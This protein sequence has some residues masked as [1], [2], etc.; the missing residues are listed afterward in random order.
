MPAERLAPEMRRPAHLLVVTAAEAEMKL[1]RFLQRRLREARP[2]P[3]LHKWIRSGQVRINGGRGKAHAR[4]AGGDIVRLPPFAVPR[5]A[6]VNAPEDGRDLS[7]S[8]S[9]RSGYGPDASGSAP[10]FGPGL[11]IVAVSGDL[12]VLNKSAGLACHPGS[13]PARRGSGGTARDGV[14]T[15]LSAAFA[16]HAYIP[17]PAHRLDKR[18]S[19]LLL[20]GLSHARARRLH[21]LFREGGIVR[22]YLAWVRGRVPW[23]GMRILEDRMEKTSVAGRERACAQPA[24]NHEYP[25]PGGSPHVA[26]NTTGELR[27]LR[28]TPGSSGQ[29]PDAL[30]AALFPC[31]R[32]RF[33]RGRALCAALV[34]QRL[35]KDFLPPD[36]SPPLRDRAG[37]PTATLLLLRPLT[38]L[39][40]QLRAQLAARGFPVIGDPL[41]GGP[42][43]RD[44][45]L[46]ACALRVPS[47][48]R[49][50]EGAP[51]FF[52]LPPP[53]GAPFARRASDLL[54]EIDRADACSSEIPS[55]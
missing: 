16:A 17:A 50:E 41:Y 51:E 32:E 43:F 8:A 46:H 45:L 33:G 12:L 31:G 10:D 15:R 25:L 48:E 5:P 36:L 54:R 7:P 22:Y 30:F 23:D 28:A 27:R 19:G 39:K 47:G 29:S 52:V 3:V 26:G 55:R 6:L 13:A 42:P 24:G 37:E 20:A 44:L 9:D 2:L 34:V 53:W 18:T 49:T 14:S 35:E 1:V 38:G 21:A 40:H 4:L 11:E